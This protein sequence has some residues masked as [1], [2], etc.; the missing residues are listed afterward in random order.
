M[1]RIIAAGL[2]VVAL[3]AGALLA[4]DNANPPP[5]SPPAA[6]APAP[7]GG[8]VT[9]GGNPAETA[10]KAREGQPEESLC[11]TSPRSPRKAIRNS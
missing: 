4:A 10:K 7:A 5:Q 9:A 3:P 11:A 8:E 6:E 2:M 1:L